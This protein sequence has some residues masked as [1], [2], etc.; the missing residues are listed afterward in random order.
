MS[1]PPRPSDGLDPALRDFYRHVAGLL[2]DANVPVL[3]G[4]AYAL[5]RYTGI[6]RH[7][8]DFDL[9]LRPD[10]CPRA[11]DVLARAGYRTELTFPHWLGKVH[12][13]DGAL[14]D[15]IFSSGNG[16][17]RVDDDWFAYAV[18]ETVLGLPM[19]L[20]PVEETIWSKSFVVERERYDGADIA[21]LIR[22]H[23]A[24]L[25]WGRLLHRF[26]RHWR[27][28]L[29]HLVFYGFIYPGE[30][31]RVPEWVEDELLGRLRRERRQPLPRASA[32]G[33]SCRGSSSWRTSRTGATRTPG[34]YRAAT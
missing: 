12:Y 20:C 2:R 26:D 25:D 21:H 8:K 16:V 27:V 23:G 33:R 31:D 17:A 22:A 4:G 18:P 6:C 34:S 28:L 19:E 7:T 24:R 11:L 30:R 13:H 3:V 1:T 15:L 32:R 14:V 29:A 5:A 10:D 9:F